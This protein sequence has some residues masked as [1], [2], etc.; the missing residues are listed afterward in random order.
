MPCTPTHYLKSSCVFL[1]DTCIPQNFLTTFI[2]I[3]CLHT[4]TEPH[5]T[6]P[7][8]YTGDH[9]TNSGG[10]MTDNPEYYPPRNR[11]I[12]TRRDLPSTDSFDFSEED[13]DYWKQAREVM[14]TYPP[15]SSLQR[16]NSNRRNSKLVRFGSVVRKFDKLEELLQ[17][18]AG[19]DEGEGKLTTYIYIH[20]F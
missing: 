14:K 20:T 16:Q 6:S 15:K 5:Q 18:T 8:A 3:I 11:S 10:H 9:M 7:R 17:E 4:H 1:R 13:T 12:H 2:I 19:V